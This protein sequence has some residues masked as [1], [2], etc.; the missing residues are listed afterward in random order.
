[1]KIAVNLLPFRQQ[2]AGAGRYAR[3]IVANLAQIDRENHYYLFVTGEGAY[4]FEVEKD[5]FTRVIC[6]CWPARLV[7]ILWEQVVF[8]WQLLVSD[9]TL[10]FTPSVVVPWWLPC[11][12]VTSIHDSIPFH[13][14]VVKYPRGRSLYVRLATSWSAKRSDVV[15]TGSENSRHEIARFC[16]IPEKKILVTPYG[17]E[18][19]FR[20][21]DSQKRMAAFRS[22]SSLPEKFMLFVGTLEPGKNLVRLIQAFNH[23]RH[24]NSQIKHKL[25]LA[26]PE[27]W[28]SGQIFSTIRDL[29]IEE[30]VLAMG[31]VP[32]TDLPW[33]YNAADLL[34]FPSLYEGFGFPPLEAMACG[35]PVVTSNS[36]SLPEVVGE[37]GLLVDPYD[38]AGWASAMERTL[39]D[40][41][42][43]AEMRDRGLARAKLFSW[44]RTARATLSI[45]QRMGNAC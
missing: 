18:A 43:R 9:A 1:M 23:L 38:V 17:V 13:R 3:N 27:G 21:M 15:L 30:E 14:A 20:P 31:F 32:E 11:R 42:L 10:L 40:E 22:Q 26:G 41:R 16:D 2:L 44:D 35:T 4:H 39:S 29:G 12:A 6:P 34:V 37:A 25:V 5:N 45:F 8:P 36:S 7:R 28:G 24:R 33:L 19:K